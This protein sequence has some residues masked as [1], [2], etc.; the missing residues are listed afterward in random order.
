MPAEQTLIQSVK[1]WLPESFPMDNPDVYVAGGFI[2]TYF[3][4]EKTNDMD[5]FFTHKQA[6]EKLCAHLK[7]TCAMENEYITDRAISVKIKNREGHFQ[8]IQLIQY[9]FGDPIDVMEKFDFTICK[10]AYNFSN[11]T[12][13]Y[14]PDFFK[15]LAGRILK[16]TGSPEPLSSLGRAFKYVSKGYHI[17]DENI[18]SIADAIS[19]KGIFENEELLA[20]AIEGMDPNGGRRIRR[21]D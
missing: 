10:A 11:E 3:A 15:D 17:C 7:N 6:I 2:R 1:V 18:I 13:I 5:L 19:K 20:R 14:H 4:G 9:C 8:K 12:C 21:I 16:F